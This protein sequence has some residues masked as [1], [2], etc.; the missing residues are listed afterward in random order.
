MTRVVL[1]DCAFACGAPTGL[2]NGN[3]WDIPT[4]GAGG[5]LTT[6][7]SPLPPVGGQRV[8]RVIAA[9]NTTYAQRPVVVSQNCG[10]DSFYVYFET[11]GRPSGVGIVWTFTV[12][13]G[14]TA[15][16]AQ[17]RYNGAGN[18]EGGLSGAT[19]Q[20]G[21][22]MAEGTWYLVETRFDVSATTYKLDWWINGVAQTQATKTAQTIGTVGKARLGMGTAGINMTAYYA[23]PMYGSCANTDGPVGEHVGYGFYPV[24]VGTHS[25][26]GDFQNEAGTS[27]TGDTTSWNRLDEVPIDQG[28]DYL[29]Q[30]TA[31]AASFLEHKFGADIA[32]VAPIAV[33]HVVA[34]ANT[35][36]GAD[37]QKARLNDGTTAAD[38][39]A[40]VTAGSVANQIAT[41]SKQW[42]LTPSGGAWTAAALK[43]LFGQWG[44][45]TDVIDPPAE[46]AQLVEAMFLPF[47]TAAAGVATVTAAAPAATAVAGTFVTANA[48]L[49]TITSAAPQARPS[50]AP[51]AGLAASTVVTYGRASSGSDASVAAALPVVTAAAPAAT[52]Q[53][54]KVANAGLAPVTV[55][56]PA[57]KVA[58]VTT[59][60]LPAIAAA[61]PAAAPGVAPNAGLASS[62]VAAPP[63]T[64]LVSAASVANAGAAAVTVGA[65]APALAIVT[66][67]GVAKVRTGTAALA[68][69]SYSRVA[70]T[71]GTADVG[72]A[73]TQSITGASTLTTDGTVGKG[74]LSENAAMI[75]AS[76]FDVVALDVDL[77]IRFQSDKAPTTDIIEH[78][79]VARSSNTD[80]L[81]GGYAA[82]VIIHEGTH[83]VHG[84]FNRISATGV[85][86]AIP[87]AGVLV[88]G[89]PF[90]VANTWWVHRF[91]VTGVNPTLLQ[92]KVYRESDGEPTAWTFQTTDSDAPHQV[93]GAVGYRFRVDTNTSDLPY[94]FS[95]DDFGADLTQPVSASV[96]PNAG[97]AAVVSDA[98]VPTVQTSGA[99]TA[100]AGLASATVT[101][102]AATASVAPNA[103]LAVATAASRAPSD[104]VLTNAGLAATTAAAPASSASVGAA[105]GLAATTASAPAPSTG[106]AATA[107]LAAV[108]AASRAPSTAVAPNAGAATI[109][110]VAPVASAEV[111][112]FTIAQAGLAGVAASAPA[113]SSAIVTNAAV[114]AVTAAAPAASA[115]IRP[116]AG[117][118]QALV[119]AGAPSTDVRVTAG[120][121]FGQA[122]AYAP[123]LAILLNAGLASAA[124]TAPAPDAE[125]IVVTRGPAAV[126]LGPRRSA[127]VDE[128]VGRSASVELGSRRSANMNGGP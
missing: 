4:I 110:A 125:G 11:G 80:V 24:A 98:P 64:A 12:A 123:A 49:A 127:A 72:G 53:S 41:R 16:T 106:L 102:P 29:K 128:A 113:P 32:S 119:L 26:P 48:G 83:E 124:I 23:H 118:A 52:A 63:A 95:F 122:N 89:S 7:T 111:D 93:P 117:A 94:V 96:A 62:S 101:A 54:G 18:W 74:L 75:A 112:V 38:T 108:T 105:A 82:H 40:S 71:L 104:A 8:L 68:R 47:A 86:T 115:A 65:P 6:L 21:P 34:F 22:A 33:E 91:R 121:A 87:G 60:G 44:F 90:W 97:L 55:A 50:V 20:T 15:T 79:L 39:Y 3:H 78:F 9:G 69:D 120:L 67:S 56:A 84:N 77:R 19:F 51:N 58:I 61:S 1:H 107:G 66:P 42:P 2:A 114:A 126:T 46:H 28:G 99:I 31:N 92:M 57:A 100:I 103:G 59:A 17:L 81:F 70:G 10:F 43:N 85:R 14:T 37:N 45:S 25:N 35:S 76:L 73:Y 13:T 88:P 116:N 5:S 30:V 109:S 36:T 27:L